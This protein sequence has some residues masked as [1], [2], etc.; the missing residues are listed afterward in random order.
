MET[1]ALGF[2][3]SIFLMISICCLYH[4]KLV[5]GIVCSAAAMAVTCLTGYSWK[6]MLI[7]S[8]KDTTLLGFHRYP[9]APM[10]LITL[11]LIALILMV[12]SIMGMVKRKKA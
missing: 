7:E 10:I 6:E 5:W 1:M 3:A 2:A 11:L 12:L 8:G 9:A 4:K